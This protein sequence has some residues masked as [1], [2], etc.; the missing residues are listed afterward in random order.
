MKPKYASDLFKAPEL[1]RSSK[2][3]CVHNSKVDVWSLG[4]CLFMLLSGAHPFSDKPKEQLMA[5]VY[6]KNLD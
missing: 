1:L 6:D 5:S 2:G 3:S 4:V